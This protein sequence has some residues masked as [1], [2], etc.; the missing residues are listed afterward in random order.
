VGTA[1]EQGELDDAADRRVGTGS[2]GMVQRLAL[3][4]AVLL[5]ER[6]VLLDET[7]SG[8]D[9]L[10]LRR[11]RRRLESIA[12]AGRLVL[13][14]SHDLAGIERLASRVLVLAGGM[15]RGDEPIARLAAERVAELTLA[16]GSLAAAGRILARYR[17]A[18]R[19]G[20]GVAVPL[21]GG[22]SV[23]QVL[24]TCRQDRIAVVGSRVRYRALEDL[25]VAA[26]GADEFV[27]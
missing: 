14:A 5:G 16:G 26:V 2:R 8:I 9:P 3:A 25:L 18:V 19:T 6:V 1:V 24:A 23:E 11:L 15:V 13:V 21:T 20:D 17:G 10:V 12:A 22:V 7:L 4:G 27:A